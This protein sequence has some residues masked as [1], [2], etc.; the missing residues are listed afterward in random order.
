[1]YSTGRAAAG[2]SASTGTCARRRRRARL[3]RH[4]GRRSRSSRS[5]RRVPTSTKPHFGCG[6][7][8][9]GIG[10]RAP[11][12]LELRQAARVAADGDRMLVDLDARRLVDDAGHLDRR[13]AVHEPGAERGAV[14]EIVEQAAAAAGLACTTTKS[15][16]CALDLLG[17]DLDLVGEVV[18]RAAVAVVEVDLD[19]SPMAPSSISRLAVSCEGYQASGQLIASRSP[20]R[21]HR[22]DHPVGVGELAAKGFSTRTLSPC[23]AIVST[24]S[25]CAAVAGADDGEIGRGH[26]RGRLRGR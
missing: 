20:A 13:L 12:R 1:M 11:A 8:R 3:Q 16:F 14:A 10:E 21:V 25:A 26:R 22:G 18:E 2:G 17:R 24:V 15:G 5:C 7:M 19:Q 23:G 9:P 6:C 4:E